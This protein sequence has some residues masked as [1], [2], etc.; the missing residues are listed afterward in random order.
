LIFKKSLIHF[1]LALLLFGVLCPPAIAKDYGTGRIRSCSPNGEPDGLHFDPSNGGKDAEFVMSNPVCV[2]F[3]AWAYSSTKVAIS[4]M[5]AY[6]ASGSTSVRFTPSPIFDSI[7]L[8]RAAPTAA[9]GVVGG[10]SACSIA[11]LSALGLFGTSIAY[12]GG[13]YATAKD[14]YKSARICG[15]NWKSPN[16]VQYLINSPNQKGVIQERIQE[17]IDTPSKQKNLTF[18][19]QDYREWYYDGVEVEDNPDGGDYC[20][21][22]TKVKSG[23]SY[24]PQKYYMKG[25]E[26]GNFNCQQYD[27]LPGQNDPRDDSVITPQRLIEY[28]QA[29]NCC[30][31][32]S[33]NYVCIE[34]AGRKKFCRGGT[35]CAISSTSANIGK[36][37]DIY[38]QTKVINNGS[39]ICAETYSLCPYNFYLGGG[40]EQCEYFQDGI[41]SSS[42]GRYEYITVDDVK[43]KRCSSKSEIRN[44]D[45]TYNNKA[46]KCKNYCQYM[47]HCTKV[48][49]N[50]KY[51]SSLASPFFSNA[52]INFVGDS[53]NRVSDGGGFI[54]G[55]ARHFS[56]PIAQCIRETLENLFLNRAGHTKCTLDSEIANSNF[57]CPSGELYKEGDQVDAKS[58]F[59]VIQER[60]VTAVK[61]VLTLSI[62][63]YGA[64]ILIAGKPLEQKDLMM[65]LVKIGLILFFA[66]G[67]AWQGFFF[68]GVYKTSM[69]FANIV[70]KIQVSDEESKRDGCQFGT[71]SD[72]N[73][74]PVASGI[75]YPN[76][77]EYIA[78]WDT[79]DC[80]IAKYMGFGPEASTSNLAKLILAGFITG[81]IGLYFS[82]ALLT[83]GFILISAT[84]KAIHIFVGSCVAIII[85]VFVSPITIT[86]ALFAKTNGIFNGWL[87]NLIAF[88][89]QPMLLFAYIAIFV[90]VLDK[91]L[92]GSATY[93]GQS[94][95]KTISCKSYCVNNQGLTVK[96]A[97]S[98]AC[99]RIGEKIVKPKADSFACL[100]SNDAFGKW[101]GLE[102]IGISLPFIIEI[103]E[104]DTKTKILT[105]IKAALVIYFLNE[106]MGEIPGITGH[107]IGGKALS[108]QGPKKGAASLFASVKGFM[109]GLQKRGQRLGKS[110]ASGAKNKAVRS[111]KYA[112]RTENPKKSTEPPPEKD[113]T[114]DSAETRNPPPD[115]SE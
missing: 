27:I 89:L 42:S 70:F 111:A 23:D 31:N 97:E 29:Y 84:I 88:T 33:Q 91:T 40:S 108:S 80:K 39:M 3:A 26:T 2:A 93:Y 55:S 82:L 54:A 32:R 78:I 17:F 64:K 11:Y 36:L 18:D 58:F 94:P 15:S 61:M 48:N 101:P 35:R 109:G 96:P 71:I 25:Y 65:Y 52:C 106:F 20:P 19:N 47:R 112:T 6:C 60:L 59:D 8:I 104:S 67:N 110:A 90:S 49:N 85:M 22:V 9:A 83:F 28:R 79:L 30:V 10:N 56:A 50:Y 115:A 46:G 114:S 107:L 75:S 4:V 7:D 12:L 5:N 13:V 87:K 113:G 81:P 102:L 62:V 76:G 63:F 34:Y 24:P 45:C 98:P 41:Y 69:I 38:F 66:T 53:Q 99:D 77:K 16:P 1:S 37:S 100:V 103:F 43:N 57:N 51:R 14:V 21:D 95:N 105:I 92:T 68:D 74:N 86:C 44:A 73:G 72:L